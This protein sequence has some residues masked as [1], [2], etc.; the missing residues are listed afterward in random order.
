[1]DYELGRVAPTIEPVACWVDAGVER[2]IVT[3]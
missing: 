1:M 2:A 3:A